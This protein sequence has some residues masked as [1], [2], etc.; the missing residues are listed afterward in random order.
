MPTRFGVNHRD[1]NW[2][3]TTAR[4]WMIDTGARFIRTSVAWRDCQPN[5]DGPISFSP[6]LDAT[7]QSYIDAGLSP[8][9]LVWKA[10][11]DVT[12]STSGDGPYDLIG[13]NPYYMARFM[14]A[15]VAHYPQ[16]L[17]WQMYNEPDRIADTD[18][19]GGWG[20]SLGTASQ[21]ARMLAAV[22]DSVHLANPAAHVVFG[23]VAADNPAIFN[24]NKNYPTVRDFVSQC[25]YY[26]QQ[27]P[28]DY[29]DYFCLH[30]Y[31]TYAA[32][33]DTPYN[34]LLSAKITHYRQRLAYYGFNKLFVVTE[35]GK[36]STGGNQPSI[37]AQ[38][39][40]LWKYNA[41]AA[42]EGCVFNVLFSMSDIATDQSPTGWGILS[43]IG[44]VF[45][46]KKSYDGYRAAIA[47]LADWTYVERLWGT[48]IEGHVFTKDGLYQTVVWTINPDV[49][50]VV[51]L[52][53]PVTIGTMFGI[54]TEVSGAVPVQAPCYFKTRLTLANFG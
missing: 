9:V 54:E 26:M 43:K 51:N 6:A 1:G 7:M 22:W 28:D 19:D 3:D 53:S 48:A 27:N 39:V 38:V 11:P 5:K 25:L 35:S 2:E 34:K 37:D 30:Y 33:W 12:S 16:V 23:G 46:K 31:P 49:A 50:S 20:V 21:Y 32:N 42:R 29:F 14:A 47:T 4:Q 24:V 17:W 15:L 10:P 44:G 41:Q 18:D 40:Y 13:G 45:A 8:V 36:R 52:S